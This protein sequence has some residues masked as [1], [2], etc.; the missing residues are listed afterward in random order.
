[1]PRINKGDPWE[2]KFR[3]DARSITP[4]LTVSGNGRGAIKSTQITWKEL[5]NLAKIY[6]ALKIQK[7]YIMHA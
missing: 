1:M 7:A 2:I 5:K 3:R 4:G 6:P